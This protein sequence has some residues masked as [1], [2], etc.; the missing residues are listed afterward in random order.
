[1]PKIVN[2]EPNLSFYVEHTTL[3]TK[4]IS[5]DGAASAQLG[6]RSLLSSCDAENAEAKTVVTGG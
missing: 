1:M 6:S 3:Y 5:T 4:W 2:P